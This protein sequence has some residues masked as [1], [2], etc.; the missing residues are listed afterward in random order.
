MAKFW[1]RIINILHPGTVTKL[2]RVDITDYM[3][4]E[5]ETF[6]TKNN[7]LTYAKWYNRCNGIK[8]TLRNELSGKEIVV[9]NKLHAPP[10]IC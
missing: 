3:G 1:D 5:F 6:W 10:Y 2:W 7:A 8:V 9:S 4:G